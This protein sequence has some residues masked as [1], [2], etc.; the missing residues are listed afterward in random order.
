MKIVNNRSY[1]G[2]LIRTSHTISEMVVFYKKSKYPNKEFWGSKIISLI[3]K[4]AREKKFKD[5][6]KI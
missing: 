1:P 2:A 4:E 3:K 5:N 6:E